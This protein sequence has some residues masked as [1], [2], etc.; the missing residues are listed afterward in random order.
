[1]AYTVGEELES[2]V[3]AD[4]LW[5]AYHLIRKVMAQ[6]ALTEAAAREGRPDVPELALALAAGVEHF[7]DELR[8]HVE[9]SS[10]SFEIGT[11]DI[12]A[13]TKK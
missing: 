5:L 12:M 6:A 4:W 1:M 9:I 13:D 7:L 10:G 3:P 2:R 11:R 8:R